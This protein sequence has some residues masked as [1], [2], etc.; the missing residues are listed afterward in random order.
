[1]LIA[2]IVSPSDMRETMEAVRACLS[3]T[4]LREVLVLA[5]ESIGAEVFRCGADGVWGRE[6]DRFGPEDM[7]A[8]D[9]LGFRCPMAAPC[10][11]L[12]LE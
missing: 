8:L 1:V 3:I 11:G 6:P 12:G 5:S 10:K 4:S 7:L 2:E 9:S